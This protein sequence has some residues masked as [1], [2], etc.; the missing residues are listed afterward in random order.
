MMIAYEPL[1]PEMQHSTTRTSN[2]I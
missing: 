2:L 1:E